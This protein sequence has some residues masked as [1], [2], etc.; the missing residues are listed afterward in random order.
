[1]PTKTLSSAAGRTYAIQG[2]GEQPVLGDRQT[3]PSVFRLLALVNQSRQTGRI[4][5]PRVHAAPA[6]E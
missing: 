4:F 2:G 1:M 3:I 6:D 5:H